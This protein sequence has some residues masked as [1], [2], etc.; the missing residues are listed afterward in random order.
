MCI[1]E[2]I[3]SLAGGC[4]HGDDCTVQIKGDC[5]HAFTGRT[6]VRCNSIQDGLAAQ[7]R[8][9]YAYVLLCLRFVFVGVFSLSRA[10]PVLVV[11]V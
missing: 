4:G 8:I 1:T 11:F 3:W 2:H 6:I 10:N 7:R 9:A 5:A